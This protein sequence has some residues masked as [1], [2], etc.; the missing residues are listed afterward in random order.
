[1]KKQIVTSK[2]KKLRGG[3]NQVNFWSPIGVTQSGGSRYETGRKVP[4]P[5]QLLLHLRQKG[6]LTDE[7]LAKAKKDI[8]ITKPF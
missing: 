4:M 7:M 3:V 5:V 6:I 1:M 2:L 8:A